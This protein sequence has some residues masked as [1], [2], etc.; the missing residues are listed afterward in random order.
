MAF[1]ST[2]NI[3][4]ALGIPGEIAFDSFRRVQEWNLYSNGQ[5]QIIGYAFTAALGGNPDPTTAS[6]NAGNAQVGGTGVFAGILVNPKSYA[7]YGSSNTPLGATLTLPDYTIGEL[8]TVGEIFVSLPAAASVGDLV[9]YN[10]TTG[11]LT[12][13][14]PTANGT[15]AISTTTLT[16]SAVGTRTAP[17][18]VGQLVSGPNIAPGTYITALGTGTGGTGT[19]TVNLSQTA[20]SGAVSAPAL[21]TSGALFIP[22]AVVAHFEVAAA[23]VACIKL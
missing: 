15:G 17:F 20:A 19:Y 6:P 13:A 21:V 23:G 5:A 7:S 14:V 9:L 10:T 4:G 3:Y 8:L 12:T 18:G 1:Q 22:N 2:V 11:A 16:I